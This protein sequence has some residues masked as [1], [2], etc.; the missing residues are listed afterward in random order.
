MQKAK[1]E[2]WLEHNG[3]S[4]VGASHIWKGLHVNSRTGIR[5]AVESQ[6]HGK[7]CAAASQE[8][9]VHSICK[10]GHTDQ[11]PWSV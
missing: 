3:E 9:E 6:V 1:I 7:I 2:G 11:E 5:T 10:P 8:E 4:S